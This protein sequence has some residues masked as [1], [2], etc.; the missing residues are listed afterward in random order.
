VVIL[1][2][3]RHDVPVET[4]L[5]ELVAGL[6]V[7]SDLGKGLVDGQGLRSCALALDVAAEL[8]LDERDRTT[9]YWV[10]LLRFVGCTA[11]AS[12]V[13]AVLGDE[14]AVSAA[15]ADADPRDLRDATR[16]SAGLVGRRPDRLLGFIARAPGVIREHEITSCEVA[17]TVA[18][19]L[20]L[21]ED[22]GLGLGHVFERADG[23]GN[24]GLVSG[25]DLHPATRVWQVAHHA[26][27]L[28]RLLDPASVA[29]VLRARAGGA[30]DPDVA[31]AVA[32][33]LPELLPGRPEVG[34]L[35]AVL[36]AEPGPHRTVPE[37]GLDAVL[38]VFGL[39]AD[40]KSPY[41]RGHSERVATLAAAGARLAGHAESEVEAVR[42]AGLV[43]DVGK[44][45]VS[46][47]IWDSH[48]A[49]SD[50]EWEQVRLHPYYTQRVLARV[51]ALSPLVELAS[52]HHERVDG[53]GY[54]RSLP[55]LSPSAAILATA[56]AWVTA[57]ETRP[58]RPARSTERRSALLQAEVEAGRLPAAAVDAV[59]AAAGQGSRPSAPSPRLTERELAVLRLVADGLTNRAVAHRLGI[60]AKTVNTH[61]EHVHAKLGVSTRTAA[62]L[63]ATR[64]RWLA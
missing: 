63:I 5:A 57:G 52:S 48:V 24:P 41:F 37:D 4:R 54:H 11:T 36:D 56:D 34:S 64:E 43:H 2:S 31:N 30:L 49:L 8:G 33:R 25:E 9:L 17:Q 6:C 45:A 62:V 35:S 50:G 7:V 13:A 42:R 29:D 12:E 26:D 61:L 15:F 22:V 53:S 27:L 39:I 51:P 20:G 1:A 40:A 46:S 10:A 38:G 14:I 28:S 3:A 32:A 55:A 59:L 23:K 19:A 44:V 47:R 60:S 58:H 16:R 18:G 21:G